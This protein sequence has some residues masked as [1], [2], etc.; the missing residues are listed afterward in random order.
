MFPAFLLYNQLQWAL[1][2]RH[3]HYAN[4]LVTKNNCGK[5]QRGLGT[6]VR[7]TEKYRIKRIK[8]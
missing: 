6:Y 3:F 2:R 7:V 4:S 5:A 8:I 1:K